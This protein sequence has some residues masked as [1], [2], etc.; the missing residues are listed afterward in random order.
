MRF[1]KLPVNLQA[2]AFYNVV[3]PD[4]APTADWPLR[5]Q[6]QFLFPK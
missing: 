5:L 2:Q 1:G 6:V 4:E 3:K